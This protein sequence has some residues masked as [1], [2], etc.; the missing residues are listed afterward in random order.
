MIL[1]CGDAMTDRYTWGAVKRISPDAPVPVVSVEREEYREGAA[2]NV[3]NNI[4]A[5]GAECMRLTGLGNPIIKHRIIGK[6]QHVVRVDY[7]YPQ[8]PVSQEEF[9]P[10]V[11]DLC[12]TVVFCDYGKGSLSGIGE[13]I[14][15]A[16]R[17][18]CRT[19][20]DPKGHDWEKYRGCDVIKPNVDE[21]R[22]LVGGWSSMDELRDKAV[23][24]RAQYGISAILVT[25]ADDGMMLIDRYGTS[26]FPAE[27]ENVCC[28]SGAGEAVIAAL[29]VGLSEGRSL[30]ES[31]RLSAKAA[32]VAC[33]RFG[34]TVVSRQEVFGDR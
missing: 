12:D 8:S 31:A 4:I 1:V 14:A 24:A 26:V 30:S 16:R 5:M 3:A 19:L 28:V 13:L 21:M 29:A 18:G 17:A 9:Y 22:A 20:I 25:M 23:N 32:A 6:G 10:I 15:T 11:E 27:A 2:W 33:S 34:T 7:D